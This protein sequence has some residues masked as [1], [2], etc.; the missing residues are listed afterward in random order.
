MIPVIVAAVELARDV[1]PRTNLLT[2]LARV[3]R[4]ALHGTPAL[5]AA[6]VLKKNPVE[7]FKW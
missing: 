6:E 5:L 3:I 1:Q 4:E 2:A 7:S